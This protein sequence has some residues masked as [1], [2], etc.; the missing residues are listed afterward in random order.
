MDGV[1]LALSACTPTVERLMSVVW[2]VAMSRTNTS[3]L[4]F[5]SGSTMPLAS[6][7]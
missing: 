7:W 4:P 3:V 6:D 5:V 1:V 2:P